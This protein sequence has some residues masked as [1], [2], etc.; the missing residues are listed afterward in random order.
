MTRIDPKN[1]LP[2]QEQYRNCPVLKKKY[3][4]YDYRAVNGNLFSCV[5][6]TLEEARAQRNQ[7]WIKQAE[8]K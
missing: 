2:G 4:Q 6:P 8:F 1:L 7:W 5:A 3:V